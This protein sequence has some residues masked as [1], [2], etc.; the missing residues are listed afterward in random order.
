MKLIHLDADRTGVN[1]IMHLVQ[2]GWVETFS[3][4]TLGDVARRIGQI[5]AGQIRGDAVV[6]DTITRMTADAREDIV[7]D[8]AKVDISRLWELRHSLK[9]SRDDYYSTM[10]LVN[11][12]IRGLGDLPIPTVYL[13]HERIRTDP[14]SGRDKFVPDLQ[15]AINAT[16]FTSADLI[17]R[18]TTAPVDFDYMGYKVPQGTRMVITDATGDSSAGGRALPTHP[19][20]PYLIGWQP[21]TPTFGDLVSALGYFPH[22]TVIYGKPKLGKTTL[23]GS[24]VYL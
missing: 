6:L 13:A 19:L 16:L 20:P 3:T 1:S 11:R 22:T 2:S 18:M 23:A 10:A 4:P 14:L 21:F 7:V 24:I 8:P 12:V 5:K 15:E 9:S 17:V